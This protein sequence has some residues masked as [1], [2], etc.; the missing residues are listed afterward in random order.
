MGPPLLEWPQ[1]LTTMLMCPIVG[2]ATLA[3]SPHL[4]QS[5]LMSSPLHFLQSLAS[6]QV[7]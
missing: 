7:L 5:I 3:T 2:L 6:T 4:K 1:A